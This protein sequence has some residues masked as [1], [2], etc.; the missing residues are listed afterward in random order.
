M[1]ITALGTAYRD[2]LE[3]A[4]TVAS[5]EHVPA[6]PPGE[7]TADQIL[8]H[9]V[10]VNAATISAACSTA[11]AAITTYDN[12]AALDTWTID[13][14]ISLAGTSE[15]LRS[16][17]GLQAD[18]LCATVAGLSE[19]ELDTAIPAL[20]LSNDTVLVDDQVPLRGLIEGLA[21]SELPGH[22]AQLRALLPADPRAA[23]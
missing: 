6:P 14:V 5:A 10:L 3:V 17:I 8:A 18:A 13:R 19:T 15:N 23:S 12:R 21:T 4:R 1:D 20:L 9:V 22:A 7:W 11:S 16:R 2:L